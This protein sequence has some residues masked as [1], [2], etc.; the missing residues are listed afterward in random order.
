MSI[1]PL[2]ATLAALAA[3]FALV[4]GISSMVAHGEIG[5][6]G[7]TQWMFRRVGFQAAAIV[8]VIVALLLAL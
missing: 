7:S 6:L 8:I 2:L 4:S 3:V 1:F 5:H